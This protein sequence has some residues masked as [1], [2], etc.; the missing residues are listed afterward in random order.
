VHRQAGND[1]GERMELAFEES[2]KA[3]YKK[4]VIIGSD[5]PELTVTIVQQAFQE[6]DLHHIVLGPATDGGYYLLGMKELLSD[7]FRDKPW[8]TD[9]VMDAT[10][11]QADKLGKHVKLLP[12]LSDLDS[13]EDLREFQAKGMFTEQNFLVK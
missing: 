1:L 6:L 13:L 10:V 3:G 4:A 12:Q 5:C 11:K 2:F 7:L 9:R 8:S